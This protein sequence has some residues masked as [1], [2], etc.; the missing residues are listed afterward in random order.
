MLCSDSL[1][2]IKREQLDASE[3]VSALLKGDRD[4][5]LLW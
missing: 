1:P 2:F 3:P 4:V 5:A